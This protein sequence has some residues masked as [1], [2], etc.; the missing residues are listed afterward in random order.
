MDKRMETRTGEYVK[1]VP[2]LPDRARSTVLGLVD[3][4]L[5]ADTAVKKD[6]T[7]KQVIERVIRTK[8]H[9]TFEAGDRTG[10]LPEVL[11]LDFDAF[12]K[13]FEDG[14]EGK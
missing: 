10:R 13:A 9:P 7:G 2:S 3:M 14:K 6:A 5:Y 11:P 1:T 8:P 12:K 4:I